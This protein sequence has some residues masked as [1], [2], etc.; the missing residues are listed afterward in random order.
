M[1]PTASPRALISTALFAIAAAMPALVH[2]QAHAQAPSRAWEAEWK[3]TLEAANKEGKLTL[4]MHVETGQAEV[5]KAFEARYPGIKV[6]YTLENIATFAPKL[7]TEQ[8][9][10]QFLWDVTMIPTSNAVTLMTPAGA[11]QDFL[12][13][14]IL[15]EATDSSKWHGGLEMWAHN[16]TPVKKIFIHGGFTQGGY[17]VNRDVIPKGELTSFEQLTDPKWRGRILIDEP[18][19][20][21]L[22]SLSLLPM[23][24]AKGPEF[25][26]ELLTAQK[27][28]FT[29][30]P[31]LMMEWYSTGR[32]PILIAERS[33]VLREFKA[34]GVIKQSELNGPL[35]LAVW[36][37]AVYTRAPNPNA[38]KVFV[39]WFL[40][41]EG[42]EAYAKSRGDYGG[43]SRR[44]DVAS[45]D[46]ENTPD[47]AKVNSYVS[48]NQERDAGQ[49][50]QVIDL[51]K[52]TRQ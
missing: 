38:A 10:G 44:N 18:S 3:R 31:R 25:V 7:V 46:P 13:Q 14:L 48:P 1:R 5:V 15:P 47:W 21:R 24:Q 51:Y 40:T 9:N 35:Y 45:L 43:V 8:R 34:R 22:G 19:A 39:N 42:Q 29:T 28:V 2:V 52:A 17:S 30:N 27:P 37:I 33:D 26:R 16:R 32:Y 12:P 41:K 6:N 20:P 11:F 23:L 36:G 4:N 49:V 50:R